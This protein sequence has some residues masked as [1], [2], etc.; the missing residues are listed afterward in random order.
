[1]LSERHWNNAPML[2]ERK[3]R[4]SGSRW[5]HESL[6]CLWLSA[7]FAQE[8][9]TA[10]EKSGVSALKP[11]FS[12]VWKQVFTQI[13]SVG[14][15]GS[16]VL[17]ISR[18]KLENDTSDTPVIFR[19]RKLSSKDCTMAQVEIWTK[20]WNPSEH[21]RTRAIALEVL[22]CG[23]IWCFHVP[24]N[25]V[26][27]C[28]VRLLRFSIHSTHS[29]LP[30]IQPSEACECEVESYTPSVQNFSLI[31]VPHLRRMTLRVQPGGEIVVRAPKRLS[32]REIHAFI[33]KNTRWIEKQKSH[34]SWFT[35]LTQ[36]QLSELRHLAKSY[37]PHRTM[38]L[39]SEL[40]FSY[41]RVSCRHQKSRWGSCSHRNAISLNIEL[42]RLPQRLRDYIIVHELTHT[43][44]KH[45]Q[46]KFWDYLEK[47]LPWALKLDRE[48]K[49]WKI[50][51]E[52]I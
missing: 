3:Y 36:S 51:Y 32:D 16:W 12:L 15:H 45:H 31:R 1:M 5:L 24:I 9:K 21:H 47:V 39:A 38:E 13:P 18:I 40:G 10:C 11:T 17:S 52:R 29:K 41:A 35:P 49:Q 46:D 7:I 6:I 23:L 28:S 33:L 14:K 37:L 27:R 42:M 25:S 22:A 44:H 34:H 4:F 8:R 2:Q 20:S 26:L 50:G 43:I 19:S 48:M 30:V